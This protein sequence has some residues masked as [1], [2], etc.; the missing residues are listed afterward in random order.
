M[1]L[2]ATKFILIV[3]FIGQMFCGM[4]CM[5]SASRMM[6]AFSRDGAVPGYRLWRRVN[7]KR[8]PFNAV[9][10]VAVFALVLTLPALWGNSSGVT[11]AFTAV[12]SIGVIGLYVAWV[13]PIFL[14]LRMGDR[15]VPGPW[16]LGKKYKWMCT[17]AIIEVII[18]VVG[19]FDAPFSSTGVPWESDFDW[20]TFNYTPLVTGG[21]LIIVGLWWLL[22]AKNWWHGPV[23]T[24]HELDEEIGAAPPLPE[25]P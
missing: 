14:R 1:A 7:Q 5:T 23:S 9:I 17:I 13:I 11:V 19:Y 10:A 4:S 22:S 8:V 3:A 21:V 16:T 18:V 24:I 20:N 6:Y 25:A 2:W 15:F 12:V